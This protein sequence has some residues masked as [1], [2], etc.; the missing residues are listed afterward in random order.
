MAETRRCERCGSEFEPRREHARFCSA[1][2]RVAWNRENWS[3]ANKVQQKWGSEN[4]TDEPHGSPDTG[5]SALRWAFTAMR[6][7]TKRLGRVK[8]RDRAQAFAVI[9]E[10]V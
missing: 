7:T 4:W 10:A 5:R 8:A 3:Q 9:G 6:D 1:R 2:C